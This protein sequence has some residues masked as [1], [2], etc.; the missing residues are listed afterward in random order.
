MEREGGKISVSCTCPYFDV[1]LCKHL[2]AVIMAAETQPLLQGNRQNGALKLVRRDEKDDDDDGFE[3]D[4]EDEED[5]EIAPRYPRSIPTG[6][7]PRAQLPAARSLPKPKAVGWRKQIAQLNPAVEFDYPVSRE[8]WPSRRELLYLIDVA[9]AQAGHDLRLEI[10]FRD[11]KMDGAWGKPKSQYLS[12][13]LLSQLPDANDRY[14]LASLTGATPV[15]SYTQTGYGA[16]H[17]YDAN[18]YGAGTLPFRYRL[19]DPQPEL[20]LPVICRTGRCR[21]RLQRE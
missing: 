12:R 7:P 6:T 15:H 3:E 13:E 16:N 2:W 10:F 5:F 21:L 4:E 17:Y 9:D 19:I 1:D 11:I 20:L 18:G 14:V 8:A